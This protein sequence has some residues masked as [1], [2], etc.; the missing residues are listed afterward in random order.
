MEYVISLT[1]FLTFYI[2]GNP[3]KYNTHDYHPEEDKR[4]IK[5]VFG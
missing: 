2:L 5:N 3:F 1:Y 4:P